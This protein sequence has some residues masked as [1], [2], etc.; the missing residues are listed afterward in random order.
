[1]AHLDPF[2]AMGTEEMGFVWISEII[3]SRY[4]ERR[5]YA[6]TKRIVRL[7]GR[8]YDSRPSPDIQSTWIP[9]LSKFL[10]LCENF[11]ITESPPHPELVALRILWCGPQDADFGPALLP[12]L[13]SMMSPDHPLQS[14]KLAL[15]VFC[16]FPRGW[17]SSQTETV[18]GHRLDKLLQAVGDPFRFPPEPPQDQSGK[19]ERRVYYW[20]MEAV[21]VLIEFA[22]S[23][24]RRSHLRPSNFASCE[25]LLSTDE[26]RREALQCMLHTASTQPEF[27]CTPAKI[28]AAVRHLEELL[29]LHTAQVV[30]MWAWIAGMDCDGR[31]LIEGETFRF[32]QTHG[33]QSLASLKWCIIQ[34]FDEDMD[35]RV[36]PTRLFAARYEGPPFRVGRSRRPSQLLDLTRGISDEEEWETD[37]VL[38]H[39]CLL[40]RLYHLFGYNPKTWQEKVG[41][42]GEGREVVLEHSITPD[43]FVDWGCDYP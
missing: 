6:A 34:N 41:E 2:E 17:F 24:L 30:I 3:G 33:V 37:R 18:S 11:S 23:E 26:G 4:L 31:N 20:P 39:A 1:M 15:A 12:T 42:V 28:I 19:L 29:C 9:I 14:R 25:D 38:S 7:L 5:Q 35:L 10:S 16:R 36:D 21:V 27:L 13:A 43:P 22:S 40:R 32:Y 8:Y